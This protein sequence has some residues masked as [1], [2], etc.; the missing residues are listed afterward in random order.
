LIPPRRYNVS[1][2][3]EQTELEEGDCTE[4]IWEVEGQVTV[5]L[6]G[7]KVETAGKK[8]V[9]PERDTDYTLT[10]QIAGSS[11]IQRKIVRIAVK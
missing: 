7:E 11:E 6:N 8:E 3:A 9:C 5:L 2:E 10:T 1:F 4:L